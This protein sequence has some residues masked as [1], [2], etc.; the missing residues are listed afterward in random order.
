MVDGTGTTTYTYDSLDRL[1][2]Q[3]NGAGQHTGYGYDLAGHLT[4]LT[5]PNA[6][7]ITRGYD[8]AGRLT[9]ITDWAGHTPWPRTLTGTPPR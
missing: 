3:S 4:R 7:D 6:M 8:S 1:T 2:D 9:S 5:Y